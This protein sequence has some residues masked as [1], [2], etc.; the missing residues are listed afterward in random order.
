MTCSRTGG[1]RTSPH[2][3]PGGPP[4]EPDRRERRASAGALADILTRSLTSCVLG[5]PGD[6]EGDRH[7]PLLRRLHADHLQPGL[8][9]ALALP[10][11]HRSRSEDA[12]VREARG[13]R[14]VP[15]GG[16]EGRACPR[17]PRPR[18]DAPS[19]P[20]AGAARNQRRVRLL[21]H[22]GSAIADPPASARPAL[23]S[24]EA[25]VHPAAGAVRLRQ[26]RREE[27]VA[28]ASRLPR[29]S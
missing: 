15:R 17:D 22:A 6:E 8:L 9:H 19:R 10:R 20:D 14:G 28:G 3:D 12:R 4:A 23:R 29:S 5:H 13:L 21:R 25:I 27:A 26:A 18:A 24:A 1:T 11:G 7:P 2:A 16:A